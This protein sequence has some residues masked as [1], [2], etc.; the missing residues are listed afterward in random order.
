MAFRVSLVGR[1][2]LSG[3]IYRQVRHAV[4]DQQLRPGDRLPAPI[5]QR[6]APLLP[7]K[8]TAAARARDHASDVASIDGRP[9]RY[10]NESQGDQRTRD[11]E[12]G[13]DAATLCRV[14]AAQ[15]D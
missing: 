14:S 10:D 6:R 8:D 3:E 11:I 5:S 4:L 2:D 1:R 12:N 15:I 7:A 9:A 13:S